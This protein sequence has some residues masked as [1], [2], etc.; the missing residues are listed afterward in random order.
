MGF[1][2]QGQPA[3]LDRPAI[4]AAITR[5]LADEIAFEN[6][7]LDPFRITHDCLNVS[8]HHFIASCGDVVCCHCAKVV[9]R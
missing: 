5:F 9:W 8:G 1:H 4:A 2:R 7:T 3:P 6:R